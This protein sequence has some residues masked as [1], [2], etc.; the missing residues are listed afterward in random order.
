MATLTTMFDENP[1]VGI[2]AAVRQVEKEV[3]S[4]KGAAPTNTLPKSLKHNRKVAEVPLHQVDFKGYLGKIYE[5]KTRP[6]GSFVSS[7]RRTSL[8]NRAFQTLLVTPV[9]K[10]PF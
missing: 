2:E 10:Q 7:R 4:A 6:E 8:V 1:F 5:G 9:Y 3:Q